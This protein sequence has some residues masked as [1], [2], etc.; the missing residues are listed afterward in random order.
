MKGMEK[1]GRITGVQDNAGVHCHGGKPQ[2]HEF[3][4]HAKVVGTPVHDFRTEA[5]VSEAGL[6]D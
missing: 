3:H 1:G 4:E 5:G 6:Q 2:Q